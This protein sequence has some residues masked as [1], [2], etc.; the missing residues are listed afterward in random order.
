MRVFRNILGVVACALVLC[1]TGAMARQLTIANVTPLGVA[2]IFTP[3]CAVTVTDSIGY[4]Q[5][6][7][8]A[9]HGK[10]LVR[11]YPGLPGTRAA[12]LTGYSLFIDLQGS[13]AL[14]SP[15]C[16]EKLILDAGPVESVAYTG[17]A[18]DIFVVGTSGG[19]G[20]A[21]V[22]QN[23][24]KLTFTFAKPICPAPSVLT[25]SLYF[26]FAA[27][28]APVPAKATIIG[29]HGNIDVAVRVPKH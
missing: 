8:N 2:C 26:G 25:E 27:K 19:A 17:T 4:I 11:S 3:K 24:S 13:T 22:E 15:N 1:P 16:V 18:A 29:T 20:L 6:F 10:L 7:G 9:G 28:G 23:G 12:G 21:K 14:G 5:M